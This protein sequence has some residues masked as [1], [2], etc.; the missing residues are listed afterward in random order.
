MT[1]KTCFEPKVG[2]LVKVASRTWPGINKPGGVGKV[3]EISHE[4]GVMFVHVEYV[5]GGKEN[6]ID[7][8]FVEEHKFDED[9]KGRPSRS[10]RDR[11]SPQESSSAP[12]KKDTAAK[13]SKKKQPAKKNK[14][15]LLDASSKA[16]KARKPV[17]CASVVKKTKRNLSTSSKPVKS[18]KTK[19]AS[20]KPETKKMPAKK[21]AKQKSDTNIQ[22]NAPNAASPPSCNAARASSLSS[23]ETPSRIT[24]VLK[25][26]YSSMTKKAAN[27]VETV[28]GKTGSISEPS[29]PESTTSSLEIEVHNE[30]ATQFNSIF[31]DVMRKRMAES[32]EISEL[33]SEAKNASK[34]K[35]FSELELRSHLERLDKES[36]VMVTWDTGTV[37]ML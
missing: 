36:K 32:I 4:D 15:A 14:A 35:P 5:L 28:I 2:A 22:V 25:N 33:L 7:L 8:E 29:S 27:F 10:R 24:G 6:L 19:I 31:F 30:R 12:T 21:Q 37:Y 17:N 9:N 23:E 3:S 20:I 34:D 1:N 26:V 11:S 13:I 16:N 18:K